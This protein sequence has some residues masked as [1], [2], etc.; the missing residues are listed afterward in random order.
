[1]EIPNPN[2]TQTTAFRPFDQYHAAYNFRGSAENHP[3]HPTS[4]YGMEWSFL[5]LVLTDDMLLVKPGDPHVMIGYPV[6]AFTCIWLTEHCMF[7][8]NTFVPGSWVR[9][10]LSF[11]FPL[12]LG[13]YYDYSFFRPSF[14]GKGLD[15]ILTDSVE[16]P[17]LNVTFTSSVFSRFQCTISTISDNSRPKLTPSIKFHNL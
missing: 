13:F 7:M 9:C 16:T 15:P 5:D 14:W 12:E 17:D 2:F 1:M 4:L 6:H 11:P 3:V 10:H 8:N